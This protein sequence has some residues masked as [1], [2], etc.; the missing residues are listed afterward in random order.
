MDS[1]ILKMLRMV[2]AGVYA[3]CD[4]FG[5]SKDFQLARLFALSIPLCLSLYSSSLS[6]AFFASNLSAAIF[7][8]DADLSCCSKARQG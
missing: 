7:K 3:M 8:S 4:S 1:T 2:R 5:I 6:L